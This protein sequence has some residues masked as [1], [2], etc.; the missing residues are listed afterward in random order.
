MAGMFF[1]WS[2][3]LHRDDCL[4]LRCSLVL[5]RAAI[6][7]VGDVIMHDVWGRLSDSGVLLL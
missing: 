5:V 1:L 7:L 2:L 4:G 6:Q 3:E